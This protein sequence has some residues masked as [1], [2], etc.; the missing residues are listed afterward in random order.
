M[1]ASGCLEK[2]WMSTWNRGTGKRSSDRSQQVAQVLLWARHSAGQL[3]PSTQ[4]DSIPVRVHELVVISIL[5]RPHPNVW[6]DFLGSFHIDKQGANNPQK[7]ESKFNSVFG[8][9]EGQNSHCK[10]WPLTVLRAGRPSCHR[11]Q[12]FCL[13]VLSPVL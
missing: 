2:W 1:V 5:V 12:D 11:P 4:D 13:L 6:V 7:L 10:D 9:F 8:S 3:R